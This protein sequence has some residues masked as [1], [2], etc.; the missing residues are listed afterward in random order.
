MRRRGLFP[1]VFI[2]LVALG[3]VTWTFATDTSPQLGLDLQGGASVVLAATGDVEDDTLD[4]AVEIIRNRV[5]ALGVAEP[6]I[7]RQGDNVVVEL[8][9]VDN[10]QR[11]LDLVGDTAELQFRP[12]CSLLPPFGTELTEEST[13]TTV[14]GDATTTTAPGAT[15][16]APPTTA[17]PEGE[18]EAGAAPRFAGEGEQAAGP[19]STSTTAPGET[20][21]IPD[22]TTTTAPGTATTTLD[23]A[24]AT[25]DPT[26][27]G[28]P[29]PTDQTDTGPDEDMCQ[30]PPEDVPADDFA[31]LPQCGDDNREVPLEDGGFRYL[32]GPTLLT[33]QSLESAS[34][35]PSQASL[36]EFEVRPV[37]KGGEDGIDAFNAAA[38]IC[39]SGGAACPISSPQAQNGSLA[40]VLDDIVVSAPGIQ[41]PSFERDQIVISGSFDESS[42]KDLS[43]ALK[44][45]A[46]PVELETQ[47]VQTV[48]PTLGEDSLRAGIIAGAIGVVLV[49]LY[50]ILYYRA[51]SVI[52][53][54]SLLVW[55][56][57][58]W[59][60]ICVLS[61][62][63]DLALTLAGVVG[64]IVSVGVTVD[65][66]IVYFERLKDD[67]RRGATPRTTA[68]KS[69]DRTFRTIIT[70]NVA[71]LIGAVTLYVLT[72][73]AVRGFAFFLGIAT[74]MDIV[75]A[76]FFTRPLAVNL[77]RTRFIGRASFLRPRADAD[78]TPSEVGS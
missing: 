25:A 62:T 39:F 47:A 8:P 52:A 12:V 30:N 73:G 10:Q 19:T 72:V 21:D 31:I 34:S 33:G 60:T 57:L 71:A 50:L 1:L 43:T 20:S 59:A 76:W 2:V 6:V 70:A 46:L 41:Q 68:G 11:A 65:S 55:A 51:L 3:S 4:E 48:S 28:T 26:A 69:F 66:Y 53:L 63:I 36:G 75:I 9:G 18:G 37:F 38:A 74:A 49:C 17:A 45:G 27:S 67:V 40:I 7:A 35:G 29:C 56:A 64:L 44:Y 32:V 14:A 5:D 13:T 24:T 54:L 61:S 78:A 58:L 22:A 23:P 16:T 77:A 15:T 42:S